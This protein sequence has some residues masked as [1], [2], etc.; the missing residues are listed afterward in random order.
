MP[1]HEAIGG[2]TFL[3]ENSIRLFLRDADPAANL[4]LDDLEFTPAEIQE[5]KELAVQKWNE[6]P[7][8]VGIYHADRF[9]YR[10]HLLMGTSALLMY[11]AANRYRRNDLK[12]DIGGGAIQDQAKAAD[13]GQAGDRLMKEYMAWMEQKKLQLNMEDGFGFDQ[14]HYF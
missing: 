14:G 6:M 7:P 4:L 3:T 8:P 1:E 5:A 2:E 12:Y 10:Y 13:Y 9:P 11:M